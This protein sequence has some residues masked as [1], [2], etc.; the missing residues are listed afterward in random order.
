MGTEIRKELVGLRRAILTLGA[1]VESRVDQALE[2]FLERNSD[3]AMAVRTGD[4]EIDRMEVDIEGECLRVLALLHPVASDLRLVLSIVRI[5]NDLER[6]ADHAKSIAKR[7]LDLAT[8]PPI[9]VPTSI[10]TMARTAQEMLSD[11]LRALADSDTALARRVRETDE[12]VDNVQK[13][14]FA[15]AESEIPQRVDQT[16]TVID[17]LSVVRSV[18]R[19]AD[20]A[21]NIAEDVIFIS[22]GEV[23]RHTR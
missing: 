1:S 21:T 11:S 2:S 4:K 9:D 14:I 10:Y 22:E 8:L 18:E 17:V 3:M 23:V 20:L 15:W 6:I 5:D 12:V 19:I 13:E 7:V 16:R